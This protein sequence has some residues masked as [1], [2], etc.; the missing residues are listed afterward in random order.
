MESF[1]KTMQHFFKKNL[2]TRI[3][4]IL[5][6]A[7]LFQGCTSFYPKYEGDPI[8]HNHEVEQ[9]EKP[10]YQKGINTFGWTL[11]LGISAGV[12]YAAYQYAPTT[13]LID[14][15]A[16]AGMSLTDNDARLIQGL[17]S[18]IIMGLVN[19]AIMKD[20][21]RKEIVTDFEAKQWITDYDNSRKLVEFS[22]GRF[23]STIP[24]D[25]DKRFA[26]ENIK[27]ARF[28]AEQYPNSMYADAVVTKSLS[29][30][31]VSN[32]AELVNIFPNLD[33]SAKI[34]L[35]LI[36]SSKTLEEWL[37]HTREYPDIIAK[38][39]KELMKDKIS[40]LCMNLQMY[41]RFVKSNPS[42]IDVRI[43]ETMAIEYVKSREDIITFRNIFPNSLQEKKLE[44]IALGTI[45]DFSSGLKVKEMFAIQSEHPLLDSIVFNFIRSLSEVKI[46]QNEFSY[47]SYITRLP[48]YS[49]QYVHTINHM[50]EYIGLFPGN[51]LIDRII[52][53]KE[54]SYTRTEIITILQKITYSQRLT[55]LKRRL[56]DLSITFDDCIET[57]GITPEFLEELAK[58]CTKYLVTITDYKK[59]KRHFRGT[60]E[61]TSLE[62]KYE[63]LVCRDPENLGN[64]INTTY[65]EYSPKISPDGETLYFVR[66]ESADGYGGEDIYVS[67]LDEYDE[68]SEA[69]NIG[70]PLNNSGNNA[71]YSISQDGQELFLHNQYTERGNNPSITYKEDEVWSEPKTQ[72]IPELNSQGGYHNGSLSVDGKYLLMSINRNDAIGGNDIYVVLKDGYGNWQ[73]PINVG[74]TINTYAEESSVFIAADGETIYFSSAGHSGYGGT[75]MFMSRRL[76]NTWLNWSTPMN[77]G[78]KINSTGDDEFYVIPAKG[79][80]IYFSSTRKSENKE[81][82]YRTCLPIELRPKPVA[83]I[84][85]RVYNRKDNTAIPATVYYEDLETGKVLGSVRTNSQTGDYQIILVVGKKYGY[86]AIADKYLPQ[87][88]NLDL[89]NLVEYKKESQNLTMVPIESGQS[90]TMNNL[91]FESKQFALKLESFP[92]LDRIIKTL[93]QNP[94][95]K[96][97]IGGHTDD[98]G[99]DEN[100]LNLSEKRAFEVYMYFISKNISKERLTY[101]G[102]GETKPKVPN[103]NDQ[104]RAMN[105]RVELM[106]K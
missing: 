16:E 91:F 55:S 27:D 26:M 74:P 31:P 24:K 50:L 6:F 101:V 19:Y 75:D 56:V 21:T 52:Q 54:L 72:Y 32:R 22:K 34:K 35:E 98:V 104:N 94:T 84:S 90:I 89:V 73:V 28:F 63:E 14:L 67:Y 43:L 82:I 23:L 46:F 78:E 3:S 87:S 70:E 2:Y 57:A 7:V 95:V 4:F 88:E 100:N 45:N 51:L 17:G 81:D 8:L 40:Q 39:D 105:R 42:Y 49:L 1:M 93:E 68:W 20:N 92:E 86:Y 69:V 62:V 85:G 10:Y 47:S 64:N 36:M 59:Y 106:I 25:G 12:G 79:D 60:E 77:L 97:E 103:L 5:L 66:K 76:D 61:W 80:F 9:Y 83:L 37:T 33:I 102:Y 71:V 96:I 15:G 11:N 30:I 48:E 65:R 44:K 99:S 38:A 41:S 18:G 29:S 58:K 53:E 13:P